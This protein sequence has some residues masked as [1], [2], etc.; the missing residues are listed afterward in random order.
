MIQAR[1]ED[2]K[3]WIK[4]MG[5]IKFIPWVMN[6]YDFG[7][8]G[9]KIIYSN[10]LK[11]FKVTLHVKNKDEGFEG[12]LNCI[13]YENERVREERKIYKIRNSK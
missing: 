5:S 4:A 2:N 6:N 13:E 1:A 12:G 8:Q 9:M 3:N 7:I 11:I 10:S